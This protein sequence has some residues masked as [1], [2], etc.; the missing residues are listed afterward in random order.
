[1]N[2]KSCLLAAFFCL[3][4]ATACAQGGIDRAL[5]EIE[6]NGTAMRVLEKT[7]AAATAGNRAAT[8]LPD[9]EAGFNALFG[10]EPGMPNRQD[11]SVSQT[12]DFS[13]LDGTRRR[14]ARSLDTVAAR[15]FEAGRAAFLLA[16]KKRCIELVY[17]NA[18]AALCRER[19]C[20]L[21]EALVLAEK[22]YA[23]G[24]TAAMD[25]NDARLALAEAVAEEAENE[26]ERQALRGD[27]R[28]MNGGRPVELADTCFAPSPLP[29][30]FDRWLETALPRWPQL[31]VAAAE[32]EAGRQADRLARRESLPSLAVGFMQETVPGDTYRGLTL[33]ITVPLWSARSKRRKARADV[34]AAEAR[35]ADAETQLRAGLRNLYDRA[36]ALE[37]AASGLAEAVERNRNVPL[38]QKAVAEGWTSRPDFLASLARYYDLAGRQLQMRRAAELAKAELTMPDL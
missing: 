21:R 20:V 29:D 27:L 9:P 36:A 35:R 22:S 11:Y 34:E 38:L 32:L 16:A 23:Q 33:G 31:A 12:L 26:S 1:M 30:D 28:A 25:L 18:V 7:R 4:A 2:K 6:Q 24:Q 3:L 10:S 13:T 14:A 8:S 15:T 37:Q 17:R 5:R 19:G